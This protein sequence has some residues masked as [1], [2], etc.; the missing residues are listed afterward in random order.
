MSA[1]G[2][3]V[4][5]SLGTLYTFGNISPYIVSYIRNESHPRDLT[6]G[7]SAWIYACALVG[8]ASSMFIGGWLND[9]I[10]PRWTTLLGSWIMSAGVLLSYFTIQYSYYLLLV[11]Y[12]IL[13]GVGVGIGYIG[14]LA[15]AMRWWPK[16]K[17]GA[18]GFV[19]A[20]FGLGALIFDAV[21][22]AYINPENY[23]PTSSNS[24]EKY[25]T[26]QDLIDRVPNIFLILGGIYAVMQFVGCMLLFNPPEEFE[27]RTQRQPSVSIEKLFEV[28][29]DDSIQVRNKPFV[30][31]SA[32]S[33]SVDSH[34][35]S[36]EGITEKDGSGSGS[37]RL[38]D[39]DEK[40]AKG[41][42]S[43]TP[44]SPVT[45]KSTLNGERDDGFESSG[46]S[47]TPNII[48][49]LRPTQ[50]LRKPNFY[51][52]WI[53]FF[54]NGTVIV[55][56]ATLYKVFALSSAFTH[57]IDDH[58]LAAVGSVASIFNCLGRIVWGLLAD[59]ISYKFSFVL[60]TSIM[61][62]FLLTL[63]ST[64]VGG[65]AMFFVWVC[66]IFFC[67]GG[68]FSLFPTAIARCFGPKY[69][70]VNYGLLFT[71]QT[72]SGAVVAVLA[73]VL[74]QSIEWYGLIFII[75]GVSCL[76]FV[77][78]LCYRPKRYISLNFFT[79]TD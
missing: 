23:S 64:A 8:Q 40:H 3:L 57:A 29:D 52:L 35:D 7:T 18:N 24:G 10:G 6:S 75:S 12:G 9:K 43:S 34:S 41:A 77:L 17:G 65:D 60:L 54:A 13:F 32:A 74:V 73:T 36:D 63:Y 53:M 37:Y 62:V 4:H 67:I 55:F 21:Q 33:N 15:C 47:W 48:T 56:V 11:T 2:F 38:D 66:V 46:S 27:P 16:W 50:M 59:R 71:S 26:Q 78:A 70:A 22:T 79:E 30:K 31:S 45:E 42:L 51:M 72:I 25:F 14:P 76:G 1:A 19:V 61:S 44:D 20:G 5:L 68:N 28:D 58:F 39:V 49:S 69:V